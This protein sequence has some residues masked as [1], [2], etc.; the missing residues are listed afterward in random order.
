M[1][2]QTQSPRAPKGRFFI[3]IDKWVQWAFLTLQL[4]SVEKN[5]IMRSFYTE[6]FCFWFAQIIFF[7]DTFKDFFV[8]FNTIYFCFRT[9]NLIF[10]NLHVSILMNIFFLYRW[11]LKLLLPFIGH[12]FYPR[13]YQ[14]FWLCHRSDYVF[15]V[16][17][18]LGFFFSPWATRG[19]PH[20]HPKSKNG[21]PPP[22]G[23][24]CTHTPK[25]SRF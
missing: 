21:Y 2:V 9:R 16:C 15:L 14:Y 6:F 1:I 25:M 10:K 11:F 13:R 22:K 5:V 24:F 17:F 7:T 20:T 3:W 4:F 18:F 8:F 12:F 19:G 23:H